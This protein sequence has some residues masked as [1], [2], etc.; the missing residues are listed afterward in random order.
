MKTMKVF[1]TMAVLL[2]AHQALGQG[3]C[4]TF[5]CDDYVTV[6]HSDSL[7]FGGPFTVECWFT[8][9]GSLLND[10]AGLVS[11]FPPT[12]ASGMGWMLS[13]VGTWPPPTMP[14][15]VNGTVFNFFPAIQASF[16]PILGDWYHLAMSYDGVTVRLFVNGSIVGW[17]NAIITYQANNEPMTI[18]GQSGN[19][20]N[21]NL[22]GRMDEVRI[23]H[24][25]RYTTSFLPS[26]YLSNDA[27][28]EALYHFD[29]GA[30]DTLHDASGNGHDGIIIG[31][32]WTP[33][34]PPPP[35][36]PPIEITLDPI[37]PPII[38]PAS[39]GSFSFNAT[40]ANASSSMQ[41]FDVW[42]TIEVPGGAQFVSLGPVA[43]TMN[44]GASIVRLRNQAVPAN[45]PAGAYI[46]WGFVG[47]PP[48]TV[49]NSDSFGFAKSGTNGEWTGAAGWICSGEPFPGEELTSSETLPSDFALLPASPNPF[50]PSTSLTF[51]LPAAARVRLAVFDIQ[52]RQVATLVDGFRDAGVHEVYWDTAG[53]PSGIYLARLTCVGFGESDLRGSRGAAQKL[54]LMK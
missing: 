54:V 51:T 48:W 44:P 20:F 35:A 2:G 4:L 13:L 30:G 49:T 33:G 28:T 22:N 38:I 18:G 43:L 14:S 11:A 21:R 15:W 17:T 3:Y 50:N 26:N 37:N 32:T 46:Y 42:C 5:E 36:S 7:F 39:G 40:V 16:S 25:C 9:D 10:H 8:V 24:T 27:Y 47:D 34:G 52:G 6:P 29:E 23:S 45:A 1:L 31:A 12:L 19:W 41:T 53:L